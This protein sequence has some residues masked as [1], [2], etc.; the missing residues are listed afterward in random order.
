MCCAQLGIGQLQQR[1][2]AAETVHFAIAVGL[3]GSRMEETVVMSGINH[4]LDDLQC[5]PIYIP[6]VPTNILYRHLYT[7]EP[8]AR[9]TGQSVDELRTT[10]RITE[11]S[12]GTYNVIVL[13]C[14]NTRGSQTVGRDPKVGCDYV[15]GGSRYILKQYI[16]FFVSN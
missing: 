14:T 4:R 2:A 10:S 16:F 15:F 3:R 11:E 8:S 6:P 13:I 7:A 5:T 12:F 9:T 1:T